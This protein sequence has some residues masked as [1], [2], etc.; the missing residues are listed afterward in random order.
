MRRT[1]VVLLLL[2]ACGTPQERCIARETRDIRVLDRL[3][4]ESEGNLQRGYALEEV[5]TYRDR[6]VQCPAVRPELVEGQPAPPPPPPQLCLR[7][8]RET[9]TQPKAIDLRAEA[10]KL[11]SMKEK[12]AAQ[13]RAAGPAIAQCKAEFPQ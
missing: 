11:A 5:V 12:R 2:T 6:W 9:Q 7:E 4:V 13:M 1:L 3:I 8:V 10:Q